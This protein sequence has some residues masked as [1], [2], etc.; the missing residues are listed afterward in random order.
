MNMGLLLMNKNISNSID[1]FFAIL[2]ITM[3]VKIILDFF[4]IMNPKTLP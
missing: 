2:D 3:N 1:S 4:M